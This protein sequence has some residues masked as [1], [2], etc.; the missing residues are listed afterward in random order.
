[1]RLP[2]RPRCCS[3]P[4]RPSWSPRRRA[5]PRPSPSSSAWMRPAASPTS[6][7]WCR[8]SAGDGR[9]VAFTSFASDLVAGDTNGV[10][11][12]NSG[13]DVFLRDRKAR[14]TERVNVSSAGAQANGGS[15]SADLSPDGR[16][17][18]FPSDAS[19]L[20]AGDTN[21]RTDIFLRDR[22]SGRTER[23]S[24]GAGGAQ[25]T[26]DSFSG[27]GQRRRALRGVRLR[28]LQPRRGGHE[29]PSR[30][31]SCATA[32]PASTE[33]VSAGGGERR[34]LLAVDQ[35]RRAHR[36]V[37]V[38]RVEPRARRHA[39]PT[40]TSS[41]AT[42]GR[43]RRAGVSVVERRRARQRRKRRR[44]A[45]R[46]RARRGVQL[47]GHQPRRR[48]HERPVRT[49]SSATCG[50]ARPSGRA[51]RAP[52][53]RPTASASCPAV[54]PGGRFVVFDSFATNLVPGDTT[55]HPGPLRAR[56]PGRLDRAASCPGVPRVR[57]RGAERRRAREIAFA[58]LCAA[59]VPGDTNGH[60]DVFVRVRR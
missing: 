38:V 54:A 20:V 52:A 22:R 45:Q 48:R 28:G 5:R 19:N 15:L 3:P 36:G 51:S 1:M 24:V 26:S 21:G 41:C 60:A 34:Q 8:T 35:R 12:P 59:L 43:A 33:R 57:A 58:T 9:L 10:T 25:A 27:V 14:T 42:A 50:G 6:R 23:V 56:P 13:I 46:Q 49:S 16:F 44:V 32:G 7:A 40:P 2:D 55:A 18:V 53:R 31:S 30:T 17:V 4:S 37:H 11:N 39:T 47:A 29:R